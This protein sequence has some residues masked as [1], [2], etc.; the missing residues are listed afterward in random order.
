MTLKSIAMTAVIL[1][2]A[3]A[4][5]QAAAQTC[6]TITHTRLVKVCPSGSGGYRPRPCRV[7]RVTTTRRVCMANPPSIRNTP[8]FPRSRRTIRRRRS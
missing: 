3:V 8:S 1:A 6:Q 5:T 7:H 2:G 4:A